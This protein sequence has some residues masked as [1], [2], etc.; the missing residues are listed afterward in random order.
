VLAVAGEALAARIASA[1][2]DAISHWQQ[3]VQM[4]DALVYDEPPDWYYPLRESLGA[5]LLRAGRATAAEM[6]FREGVKR[7]P[8]N[9]RMLFGLMESLKAQKKDEE[10]GW[11][12][13]EFEAVWA[14]ADVKLRLEDL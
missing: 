7:S 11:V 4:Q 2:G 1:P 5:A 10:A 6:A 14:K 3:A 8:R 9:G 12:R 13:R